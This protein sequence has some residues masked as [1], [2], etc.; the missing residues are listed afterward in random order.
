MLAIFKKEMR[1]YFTTVW[2]YIFLGVFVAVF[3]IFF[4]LINI[5]SS[6]LNYANVLS[7]FLVIIWTLILVSSLTMRLFAE[8]ARQKTDQLLYTSPVPIGS[9]VLGKYLAAVTVFLTGMAITIIFPLILAYFGEVNAAPTI[10]SFIGFSLLGMCF[11]SV[12]LF[13]SSLTENQ[14]I[15][16][17]GSFLVLV[18]MFFL[19]FFISL[20][21]GAR[22]WS[23]GF[24]VLLVGI[25]SFILYN[26]TKNV[27]AAAAFAVLCAIV[28]TVLYLI[29]NLWFDSL[30]AKFLGFFSIFTRYESFT[31]GIL[32]IADIIYFLTFSAAFIYLTT[33]AIEKKRWK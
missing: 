19:D 10:T 27:Y 8:E 14:I 1:T 16:L 20:F 23:I 5:Q 12:G 31:A 26:N 13:I 32:N 11:I 3:A 30:I 15:A 9:I 18:L 24:L 29:N 21:P 33:S 17:V 6:N 28:I 25:V 22:S 7:Y 4:F 2:G